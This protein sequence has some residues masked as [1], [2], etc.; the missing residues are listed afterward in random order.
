MVDLD[1]PGYQVKLTET[2]TTRK[3]PVVGGHPESRVTRH[4]EARHVGVPGTQATSGKTTS[5]ENGDLPD[6]FSL[7]RAKSYR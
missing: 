3:F 5:C 2:V 7:N 6:G 1:V 4:P